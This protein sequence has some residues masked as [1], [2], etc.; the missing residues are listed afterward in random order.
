MDRVFG[1][2]RPCFG[3]SI[4]FF[5]VLGFLLDVFNVYI[6][7]SRDL[8]WTFPFSHVHAAVVMNTT[9]CHTKYNNFAQISK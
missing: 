2:D 8:N 1:Y 9:G 6:N 3:V 7:A 4:I 5:F